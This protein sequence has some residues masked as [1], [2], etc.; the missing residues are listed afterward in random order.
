MANFVKTV[1]GY[2]PLIIF[3]KCSI[4]NVWE[5][6]EY[7]FGNTSSKFTVKTLYIYQVNSKDIRTTSFC[8]ACSVL[9]PNP[10]SL[11]NLFQ[12]WNISYE[13]MYIVEKPNFSLTLII[14]IEY[15]QLFWSMLNIKLKYFWKILQTSIQ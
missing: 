3:A 15:F 2:K 8:W 7:G 1:N 9:L 11:V 4:S 14:Q 13:A 5:G 10:C 6:S 12:T